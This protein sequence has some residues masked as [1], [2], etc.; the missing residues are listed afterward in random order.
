MVLGYELQVEAAAPR[1]AD[2]HFDVSTAH[3]LRLSRGVA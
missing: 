3:D 2:L 1:N